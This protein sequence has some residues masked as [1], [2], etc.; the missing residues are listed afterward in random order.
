MHY[1]PT[2]VKASTDCVTYLGDSGT[3]GSVV[4]ESCD[5]RWN[6]TLQLYKESPLLKKLLTNKMRSSSNISMT[7]NRPV[8][9][10]DQCINATTLALKTAL[11][12][13]F[14]DLVTPIS[15]WRRIKDTVSNMAALALPS[16]EGYLGPF[17]FWDP[18]LLLAARRRLLIE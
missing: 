15:G 6:Q 8:V 2:S 16:G 9:L 7:Y 11:K 5:L 14:V 4:M 13:T 3:L 17:S 12:E 10:G 1:N 18:R